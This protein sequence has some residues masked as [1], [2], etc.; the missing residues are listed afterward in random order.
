[1]ELVD[2]LT[3]RLESLQTNTDLSLASM[4]LLEP[5][6]LASTDLADVYHRLR[7]QLHSK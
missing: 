6:L 1:M 2:R 5:S 4:T 7:L 3:S